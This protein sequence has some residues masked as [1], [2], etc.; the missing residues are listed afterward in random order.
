M[1][2]VLVVGAGPSGSRT[3]WNFS[4]KGYRV[5]LLDRAEI[6][7]EP[8]QCAG[9]VTPRTFEY[10][11]YER[12][13]LQ[14]MDGARLWGP[15]DS[16]L[17][18]QASE[19]K[20]LVIDRPDLDRSIAEKASDAGAELLHGHTYLGHEKIDGGIKASVK[21]KDKKFSIEAKLLVGADGPLP[22]SLIHI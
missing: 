20:A 2:D 1:L 16:F 11:G 10:L 5:V 18:F 4:K 12:P 3:A 13:I 8:C 21:N 7:G 9:L 22:L 15:K 6:I 19:T 17:D 14:E